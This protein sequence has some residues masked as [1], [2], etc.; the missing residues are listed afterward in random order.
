MGKVDTKAESFRLFKDGKSVLEIAKERKLTQQTIEGHLAH[1]VRTGEV[2]IN[3]LV[4]QEKIRLIEAAAKEFDEGTLTPLKE[5][6]GEGV[7]YGEIRLVL[8]WL[9]FKG[10]LHVPD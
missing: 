3:K 7:S 4:N 6:L 10:R 1:Y 5:K 9:G 8:A 2:D